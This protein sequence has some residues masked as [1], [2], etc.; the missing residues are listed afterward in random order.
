MGEV[1]PNRIPRQDIIGT[2][3][4]LIPI[5]RGYIADICHPPLSVYQTSGTR[6]AQ[7]YNSSGTAQTNRTASATITGVNNR[8]A[9]LDSFSCQEEISRQ[10]IDAS[11]SPMF[12]GVAGQELALGVSGLREVLDKIEARVV[13]NVQ[14]S[15]V[16]VLADVFNGVRDAVM[17]LQGFGDVIL[18]GSYKAFDKLRQNSEI[19]DRMKNTG[20]ALMGLDPREIASAQLAA[21]FGAWGV[22]EA[23]GIAAT[24]W[25]ASIVTALV[26]VDPAYDPMVLP[27]VGR[28][29]VYTWTADGVNET[30]VV[31]QGYDISVRNDVLD[32]VTM[33]DS[34][35]INS[36][37][38]KALTIA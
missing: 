7:L 31:E 11:Q 2:V 17:D 13:A 4:A 27:Q 34:N 19:K 15:P 18:V 8:A 35:T 36:A 22:V 1:N 9:N 25:D 33:T 3:R 5:Q 24:Q 37:F 20:V 21:C 6:P 30:M 28:R 26:K 10:T 38:Q 32:F 23:F 14:A 16:S 12:G 29:Y